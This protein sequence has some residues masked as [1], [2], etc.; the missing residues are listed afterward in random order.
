MYTY[1][2]ELLLMSNGNPSGIPR[3]DTIV[4]IVPDTQN[5]SGFSLARALLLR[6]S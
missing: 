6:K 2:E 5:R 4:S 1:Y 3:D